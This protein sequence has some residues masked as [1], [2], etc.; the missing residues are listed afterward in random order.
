MEDISSVFDHFRISARAIWNTAFWP[1]ADFR[2]WD[3]SDQFNEIKRI[4]FSELVLG[5]VGRDWPARDI[6]EIPIPFFQIMP[7][8]QMIPILIQ[9]PRS[10]RE[11]GYWDHPVNCLASG[12]AEMHFL[13]YFDWDLMDYRDFQYYRVTIAK[14]DARSELVG[15]DALIQRHQARVHLADK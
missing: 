1:D 7:A 3:S 11:T 8:S 4:L 12:E 10:D 2:N 13:D 14:F 15:R 5:K 6:F 9:N